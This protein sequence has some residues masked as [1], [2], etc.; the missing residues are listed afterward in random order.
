[1]DTLEISIL[2]HYH[3][4]SVTNTCNV[5]CF[6]YRDLY[7]TKSSVRQMLDGANLKDMHCGIPKD[8]FIARDCREWLCPYVI[9]VVLILDACICSYSLYLFYLFIFST[10]AMPTLVSFLNQSLWSHVTEVFLSLF[11]NAMS[12]LN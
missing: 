1:M 11:I 12:L 3:Q 2:G 6:V 10:L 4:F 5:F 9:I 7:I 8:F